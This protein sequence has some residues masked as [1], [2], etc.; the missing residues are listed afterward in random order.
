MMRASRTSAGPIPATRQHLWLAW[1][2]AKRDLLDRY[3][4]AALGL[5]WALVTPLLMLG[6]YMLAFGHLL[7]ARWPGVDNWHDFALVLFAGL[8]VH[9]LFAECLTRAPTLVVSRASYATRMVFPLDILPWPALAGAL[10]QFCMNLLVLLGVMLIWRGPPP[11]SALSLPLVLLPFLPFLLGLL[12]ALGA[13][14]VY[15]RDI[16]QLTAP[17]TTAMLFLSSAL[18]PLASLP[19]RYRWLFE[20]NPLTTII[21]QLR[22]VLF[23]G[24]WPDWPLLAL[25]SAVALLFCALGHALFRRLSPGFADVL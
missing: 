9:G 12:W 24:L 5:L 3:R 16:G 17:V 13:L 11:L 22:R 15:L 14:G 25:Y 10:F 4:G 19:A 1:E 18:V 21:E 20:L 8:A 23:F 7:K 6:V 2:L